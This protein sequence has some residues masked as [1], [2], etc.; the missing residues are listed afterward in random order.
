MSEVQQEASPATAALL[1]RVLT[2]SEVDPAQQERAEQIF[3]DVLR[4]NPDHPGFLFALAS[5]RLKQDRVP[6]ADELLRRLTQLHPE[7]VT[8]W[9]NLAAILS[10]DPR[11]L[12][13]AL[14]CIDRAIAAAGRPMAKLLDT[15]AVILLQQDRNQD[16]ADLLQQVLSLADGQDSRFHFHFAVAQ[17]RL[18]ATEQAKQ[19]WRRAMEL[20]LFDAY[21]T[22]FEQQLADE[23]GDTFDESAVGS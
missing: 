18:G 21:L 10:D 23:L 15:K 3:Q 11:R 4:Q 19:A 12:T 6:E 8:A 13:E 20:G 22:N 1:A 9:N 2:Q 14:A 16:A 17:Y 5:L 7:H